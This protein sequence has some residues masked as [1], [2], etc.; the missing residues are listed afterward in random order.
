MLFIDIRR[1]STPATGT[2]NGKT[3]QALI[4]QDLRGFVYEWSFAVFQ[5]GD[6]RSDS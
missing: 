2:K 6:H 1:S 3:P 4:N 5:S